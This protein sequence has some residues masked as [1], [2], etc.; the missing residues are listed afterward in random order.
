MDARKASVIYFRHVDV[1]YDTTLNIMNDV[2]RII[3]AIK[4]IVDNIIVPTVRTCPI[5]STSNQTIFICFI[6]G[7]IYVKNVCTSTHFCNILLLILRFIII[8]YV[9]I[10]I[11]Y[12]YIST[13]ILSLQ[14]EPRLANTAEEKSKLLSFSLTSEYDYVQHVCCNQRSTDFIHRHHITISC[15]IHERCATRQQ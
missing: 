2:Q 9:N 15:G 8:T 10:Y 7:N 1:V 13:Y 3:I 14:S 6:F 5:G 4:M 11:L 12:I